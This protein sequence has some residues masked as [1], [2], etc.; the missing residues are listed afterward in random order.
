MQ[1]LESPFLNLG[2]RV[3]DSEGWTGTITKIVRH[4]KFRGDDKISVKL[5]TGG[6]F[7]YYADELKLLK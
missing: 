1:S 5:D 3:K 7:F 6:T 2:D 4:E